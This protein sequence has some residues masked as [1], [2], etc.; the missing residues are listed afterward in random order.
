VLDALTADV[1]APFFAWLAKLYPRGSCMPP[2]A[3]YRIS[4][5][6]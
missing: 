3:V 5:S 6:A 4:Q 2:L 1:M